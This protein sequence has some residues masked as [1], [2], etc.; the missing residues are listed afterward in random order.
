MVWVGLQSLRCFSFPGIS[1]QAARQSE[2]GCVN[3]QLGKR[4]QRWVERAGS[5]HAPGTRRAERGE[6]WAFSRALLPAAPLLHG[7]PLHPRELLPASSY[8]ELPGPWL[9]RSVM[10]L[11]K[12]QRWFSWGIY[13]CQR[14]PQNPTE[15]SELLPAACCVPLQRLGKK[16]SS[17]LP[18]CFPWHSPQQHPHS[19]LRLFSQPSAHSW[20]F[21]S[22]C[23]QPGNSF[24]EKVTW[25]TCLTEA[26]SIFN[27][28]K[29]HKKSED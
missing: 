8:Q 10:L 20:W 18:P 22:G 7:Q 14:G 3:K 5:S 23:T 4:R 21:T 13:L 11:W 2:L 28:E 29:P 19:G 24:S 17:I 16:T 15:V 25:N 27:I 1:T 6:A 12:R 26:F 9:P